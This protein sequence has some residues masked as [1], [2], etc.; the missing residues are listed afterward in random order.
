[1]IIREFGIVLEHADKLLS[2]L[3]NTVLL[4]GI[5]SLLALV[6]GALIAM[7][8]MARNPVLR[9]AMQGLVDAM[10]CVPFLMLAYIVYYGLPSIGINFDNFT[11]GLVA[12]VL[13]NAAYMAEI[14]RGAWSRLPPDYTQAAQAFGFHGF[15]MYRRIIL[16][17][18]V[19]AAAPVIGNQ[20]I[21]VIKDTAFLM[22]IAVPELTHAASSIQSTYYVPFA[23]FLSA[24][25]LYWVLCALV[26]WG[27]RGIE[28]VAEGRR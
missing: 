18:I 16:P 22:I 17:P 14:L 21:Q 3:V 28:R 9:L 20:V 25:A 12:L 7:A 15:T 11:A 23:A 26:E 27:V 2:G 8:L 13:Y 24:I 19:M 5:G 1:M 10:R 6:F 4:A